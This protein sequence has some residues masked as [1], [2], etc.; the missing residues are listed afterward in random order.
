MDRYT[1]EQVRDA[2]GTPVFSS[3]GEKIGKV[4][5][6]F[7]D[8]DTNRPEWISIGTGFLGMNEKLVPMEA[9]NLTGDGFT[10]PYTKEQVKGS[11]D[12]DWSEGYISEAAEQELST[13]YGMTRPAGAA[14]GT[15]GTS[16][17]I[18]GTYRLRRWTDAG[19]REEVRRETVLE[20]EEL[21]ARG[22]DTL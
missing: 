19:D 4:G 1:I 20:E 12:A 10:V 6:V 11:P 7:Y 3:D 17:Q 13:Y 16:A 8:L 14:P 9:A 18:P 2:R 21:D 22:T 15:V 5:E